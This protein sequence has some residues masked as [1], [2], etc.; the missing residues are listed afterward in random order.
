MALGILASAPTILYVYDIQNERSIF[1]NRRFGELLGH[2]AKDN[3]LSEWQLF[4]HADDAA[5]FPEYRK[6]LKTIAPHETLQWNFRMRAASG[7]WRWF[8]T[9]D[10]LMSSDAHGKPLLIVGSAADITQQK[11]AEE[12][13]DLMAGEMRH[14]AKNLAAVVEAIARQ[15]RPKNNPVA[16]AHMDTFL[17]RLMT[18]LNTGDVVLAS[19]ARTADLGAVLHLALKPFMS[20]EG[21]R[22]IT[23]SG[24]PV[25]LSE[26]TAGGLALAAHELATNAV[27][28]GALSVPEGK[29]TLSWS[30]TRNGDTK[31]V[32]LD[33]CETGGPSVTPPE[34]PGFGT[35]VVKQSVAHEAGAQVTLD[36]KPEGLHCRF[37]FEPG[38]A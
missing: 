33:W 25:D 9:K 22:R 19:A 1:Q 15:S 13:K 37:A 21:P 17:G 29:V 4:I 34:K 8:M 2:P 36:Y 26:H 31:K 10:A 12:L 23:I 5:R 28:Y 35:R 38:R 11:R 24:P 20:D 6:K 18:L 16:A 7:E 30:A 32:V 3:T 27:K 14:R